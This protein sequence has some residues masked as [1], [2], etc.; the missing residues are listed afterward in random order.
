MLSF[1]FNSEGEVQIAKIRSDGKEDR[2][3]LIKTLGLSS[4]GFRVKHG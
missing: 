2:L 1:V 4:H 3:G